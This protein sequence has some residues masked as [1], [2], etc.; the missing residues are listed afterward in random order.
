[1][2]AKYAPTIS[3]NL[4]IAEFPL[5]MSGP[6][7]STVYDFASLRLH[8]DG[9]RVN[10]TSR[11]FHPRHARVSAQ[12]ARGNWFARD[13]AGSGVVGRYKKV[14]DEKEGEQDDLGG[15]RPSRTS[16]RKGKEIAGRR[17]NLRPA[18]RHKFLHDLD[19]LESPSLTT[20]TDQPL[21][22]SVNMFHCSA[23]IFNSYI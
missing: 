16:K 20:P 7:L 21:P 13:A 12:D 3:L 18:K 4:S 5:I 2:R 23:L 19:F 9:S 11:N 22:S 10:Q 1:M 17:R 8:P 6:R 14:R 15:V